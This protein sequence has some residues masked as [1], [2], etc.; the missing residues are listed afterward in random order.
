LLSTQAKALVKPPGAIF[1]RA[2]RGL[3]LCLQARDQRP[4]ADADEHHSEDVDR[5]VH[6]AVDEQRPTPQE[7][8]G[9]KDDVEGVAHILV[10][11]PRGPRLDG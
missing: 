4:H 8:E 1:G 5:V 10:I 6:E 2:G 3:G 11:G 7:E 9:C